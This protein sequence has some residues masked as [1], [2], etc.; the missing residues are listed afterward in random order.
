M[1]MQPTL[2]TRMLVGRVVVHDQV[3]VPVVGRLLV[4]ALEEADKFLMPVLWH[5]VTD[6][7]AIERTQRREQ[8]GGAVASVVMSHRAAAAGLQR[9]TRLSSVEGLNLALLINAEHQS[10]IGRVQVKA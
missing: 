1:A 3:Q 2:D 9:Q 10:F 8:G 6:H 5:A 4:E 7:R